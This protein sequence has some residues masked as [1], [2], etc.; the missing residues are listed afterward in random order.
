MAKSLH[1]LVQP[2]HQVIH[3]KEKFEANTLDEIWM[4]ALA[5]EA[6]W[7]IISGD[8]RIT[9][10]PHEIRAWQEAGNTTFFLKKGWI[11]LD[12]WTQAQKFVKCFPLII[13]IAARAKSGEMFFVNVNGKIET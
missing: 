11:N 4:P 7:I 8:L 1:V 2:D 5:E 9:K 10:N 6:N 3:L 13:K 12:F